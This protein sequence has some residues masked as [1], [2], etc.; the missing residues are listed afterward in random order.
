MNQRVLRTGLVPAFVLLFVVLG[1]TTGCKQSGS[2][3]QTENAITFDSIEVKENYHMLNDPANPGCELQISFLYPKTYKDKEKLVILQK[4]F[5]STFFGESYAGKTP[6]EAVGSYSEAYLS[7]YK[8]LEP[9][10]LEEK[11][12]EESLPVSSWFSYYETSYNQV[13]Y[14]QND[15]LSFSVFIENYT[16]G[17]HGG[18]LITNKTL[19]LKTGQPLREEEIF[20]EDYQDDLS[21]LIVQSLTDE[22]GLSQSVELENIGFFSVDE[23]FPNKNF[24]VN[25][26]GITY[27]FNEYE[28]ANY[29][30]GA[31]E[32]TLPFE[33]VRFLLREDSPIAKIAF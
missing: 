3:S 4:A 26:T 25:E 32:V 11:K 29:V 20:I 18:H 21:R 19:N 14:N 27:T 5:I 9:D 33:R 1:F 6:E 10:F 8:E 24:Y 30:M 2:S 22:N 16:G 23:I 31:I 15:L 7:D 13:Q 17:A 28:I 12:N